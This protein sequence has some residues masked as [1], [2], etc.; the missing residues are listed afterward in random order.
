M[1]AGTDPG[2]QDVLAMTDDRRLALESNLAVVR[3]R[4][5]AACA[6]ARRPVAEVTLIAVTKFFPSADA[7]TLAE[8]GVADLGESRD[9][10][11]STKAADFAELTTVPVRWHFVGRLQS[12][13]ARS[14]VRYADFVHSVDR[15]GLVSA[16]ATAVSR[17]E[18]ATGK[19]ALGVLVQ[20]SLD[21]DT[22]RG[23]ALPDD[24]VALADQVAASP[25]LVVRGV[26]A[27]API[28]AD[29]D[30]A[31]ERLA[32]VSAQL[33]VQHPGA[34]MVSAGMSGDLEAA[35]RHGATH[36]RIGTALLGA[37]PVTFG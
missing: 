16:L 30:E 22:A 19:G 36:L 14:V 4:I 7:V 6:A 25:G 23:G 9:Q 11:A 12:N 35:V 33:R 37:R 17:R 32:Q 27:V 13:K 1:T 10:E 8:L 34:D 18:A 20:V 2:R 21:G 31:F 15:P 3:E 28:G 26:M 24:V 29:P 5:E